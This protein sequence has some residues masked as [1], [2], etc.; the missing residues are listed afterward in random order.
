MFCYSYVIRLYKFAYIFCTLTVCHY[1]LLLLFSNRDRTTIY[2][3]DIY[4]IEEF[5]FDSASAIADTMQNLFGTIGL[6]APIFSA[7]VKLVFCAL[8]WVFFLKTFCDNTITHTMHANIPNAM[9]V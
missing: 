2:Q 1:F 5:T 6:Q 8:I 3:Q 9:C 4:D 7:M